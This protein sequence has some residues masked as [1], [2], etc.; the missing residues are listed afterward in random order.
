MSPKDRK[1]WER[2]RSYKRLVLTC[3]ISLAFLYCDIGSQAQNNEQP[4]K[5]AAV[6]LPWSR[7][8]PGGLNPIYIPQFVSITFDDNFGLANPSATGGINYIVNFYKNKQNPAGTGNPDNFDGALIRA[9]FYH[10]SIYLIDESKKVMGGKQGEDHSG[11]NRAAWTAA[12]Q[13]GHE[14]G[15]HTV[16]HFN[17]GPMPLDPDDCCRARNWNAEE[18]AAE[19]QSCKD[20]LTGPD[21]IGA[22]SKDIVGFRAPYLGY[23]DNMLTALTKIKF[24]Y[25]T[26]LPNCFDN[27]E[28]GSNCSWPYTFDHGSPDVDVLVR[29]FRLPK[30]TNHPALW[31]VPPTTLI[32]PPDS[33]ATQ[34]GFAPGLRARIAKKSPLPYPSLYEASTGKIAG[35]DYT[36][37][38]DAGLTGAEMGAVL[39]YNLDL[40]IAGNRSP[41]VFIA[42]SHL[43][44]Y[45]NPEDNPDT[46]TA[47]D[48][49]A[50][51]K[52]LTDFITYAL[53]K[54][55]T[56]IVSAKD[57][58]S[59]VQKATGKR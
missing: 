29:K 25:D 51:W 26:S 17:G 21:G 53:S 11:R 22:I 10:T 4:G 8:P 59:W 44:T 36:L 54:P 49:D 23:N 3:I 5:S 16:N 28:N 42:H 12:F 20:A 7:K 50:R 6:S 31:E 58:L 56:R 14:A 9:S 41:L 2:I 18:W 40:H 45:S 46:P 27:A 30:V 55:E 52:G 13:S 32:I 37:L 15:D 24:T 38:M 57:M 35:L 1:P 33:M 47:A 39:K 34:Y 43:Y 19:I 48:R